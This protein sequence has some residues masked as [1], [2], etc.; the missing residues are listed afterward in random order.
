MSEI[1][2]VVLTFVMSSKD[3]ATIIFSFWTQNFEILHGVMFLHKLLNSKNYILDVDICPS[4]ECH[5]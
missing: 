3:K 1:K 5:K 4:R 2:R